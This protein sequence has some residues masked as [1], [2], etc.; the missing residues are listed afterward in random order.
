M[1]PLRKATLVSMAAG[2]VDLQLERGWRARVMLLDG[3]TG[4][5]SLLPRD[6][7]REPRTWALD[8]SGVYP[9]EGRRRDDLFAPD[10]SASAADEDSAI[11]LASAVTTYFLFWDAFSSVWCFFAAGA[12]AIIVLH[13]A[14]QR[15]LRTAALSS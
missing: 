13:F 2:L 7:W 5:V 9:H 14:R 8:P 1:T 15:Q 6:G 4:R 12:S 3:H 11:V 10:A